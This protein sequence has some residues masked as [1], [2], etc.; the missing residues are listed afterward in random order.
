MALVELANKLELDKDLSPQGR[1]VEYKGRIKQVFSAYSHNLSKMVLTNLLVMIC[2]IPL[3]A[4]FFF[5]LPKL[6]KAA[7]AGMNFSGGLGIGYGVADDT[8]AGTVAIYATRQKM[9][10]YALT[11]CILLIGLGV[12]GAYYCCRNALWGAK[13][14]VFRT[15][16]R[17]VAKSWWKFLI[18]FAVLGLLATSF[19]WTV[20]EMMKGYASAGSANAGLWVGVIVNGLVIVA[21]CLF[22]MM[23]HPLVANYRFSY[24]ATI[25]NAII[26]G[27]IMGPIGL[28]I[29]VVMGLPMGL[30]FAGNFKWF[31]YVFLLLFGG[32]LY[33]I[34]NEAF[35]QY[36]SD[37]FIQ[38]LLVQKE[39]EEIKEREKAMK[40]ANKQ[41]KQKASANYKKGKRR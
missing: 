18:S 8:I 34:L 15:F 20:L 35:G 13:L 11:P 24:K 9:V 2:A 28:I 4:L 25:K 29:L 40:Q 7:I 27:L 19:S 41:K 16:F 37:N 21:V 6:E 10:L 33:I 38:M 22:L 17:G 5:Y 1:D 36:V 26:L 12:S 30:M 14:N 3:I 23:F 32:S 39:R 31:A